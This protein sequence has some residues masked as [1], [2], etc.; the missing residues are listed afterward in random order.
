MDKYGAVLEPGDV[1]V[2]DCGVQKFRESK[3]TNCDKVGFKISGISFI[4]KGMPHDAAFG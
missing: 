3:W 4:C 2:T 1:V